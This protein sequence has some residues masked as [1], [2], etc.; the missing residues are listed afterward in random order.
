ME[1]K[2]AI[3]GDLSWPFYAQKD[4]GGNFHQNFNSI[5]RRA[6]KQIS[7]ERRAYESVDEKSLS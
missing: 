6:I 7:Y 4:T 3:R 1:E 2:F 5:S